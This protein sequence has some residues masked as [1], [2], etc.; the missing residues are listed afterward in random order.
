MNNIT[1]SPPKLLSNGGTSLASPIHTPL[2][3]P[4]LSA[5][6]T[7]KTA[8]HF[9]DCSRMFITCCLCSSQRRR[10]RRR[11]SAGR[12][13]RVELLN[14]RNGRTPAALSGSEC[15]QEAGPSS[16]VS[17]SIFEEHSTTNNTT[18]VRVTVS[19]KNLNI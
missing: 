17:A 11:E 15:I 4:T 13:N 7:Q 12:V 3:S 2:T 8:R 6:P 19:I 16:G 14:N 9:F 5:T 10:Q 1:V 18:W